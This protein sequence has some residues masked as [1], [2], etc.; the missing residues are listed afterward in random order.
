MMTK[1]WGKKYILFVLA[2][3]IVAP[4]L[5][6]GVQHVW[7]ALKNKQLINI[8]P[9]RILYRFYNIQVTDICDQLI[10]FLQPKLL[11][12]NPLS[13]NQEQ[14]IR[15]V[16]AQFPFILQFS[17]VFTPERDLIVSLHGASFACTINNDFLL[18]DDERL[19]DKSVVL[20]AEK[21]ALPNM[22][23]AKQ[24][25]T[26]KGKK[27]L[28]NFIST[29]PAN[30]WNHYALTF[31]NP[32]NIELLPLQSPWPCKILC[33]EQTLLDNQKMCS[34]NNVFAD[35]LEKIQNNK[36]LP[37]KERLFFCFDTRFGKKI[38]VKFYSLKK[39]EGG[40]K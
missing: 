33:D 4:S 38:I 2:A 8:V 1:W 13:F 23:V 26:A 18:T 11:N 24:W 7:Q 30:I 3:A 16:R 34:V 9:Q 29:V 19:L 21:S 14:I 25:L 35:F 37:R 5:Y 6:L 28:K 15:D 36:S 12:I 39:R 31:N 32:W 17:C 10:S 40:R 27:M 20:K 22:T